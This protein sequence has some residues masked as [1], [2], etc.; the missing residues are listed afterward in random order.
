MLN[1]AHQGLWFHFETPSESHQGQH[2]HTLCYLSVRQEEIVSESPSR[3]RP[4]STPP[5][6]KYFGISAISDV[7]RKKTLAGPVWRSEM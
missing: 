5:R 1:R 3:D 4:F 6:L 7:F 2:A